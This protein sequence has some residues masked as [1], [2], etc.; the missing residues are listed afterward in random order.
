[1][2]RILTIVVALFAPSASFSFSGAPL[3]QSTAVSGTAT[4]ERQTVKSGARSM[5]MMPIGVPKVAY[6]MP[7]SRGGE[8]VD[9][10]NRLTRERIIFMGAEIDDEMANQIIGVLL[11]SIYCNSYILHQDHLNPFSINFCIPWIFTF[12]K[13]LTNSI[14]I[15][16]TP[17]SQSTCTS[18]VPEALLFLGLPFMIQSSTFA[19]KL[20]L[21]ILV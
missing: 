16:K 19:L 13:Q 5:T 9:I 21:S 18:I 15:T 14:W 17:T 3:R 20:W 2:M 8:W 7:G 12:S 10:Y 6:K 4:L 11:V 1:M